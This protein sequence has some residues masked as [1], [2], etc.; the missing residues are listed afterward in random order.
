MNFK[1]RVDKLANYVQ[2]CER[3]RLPL[4][5]NT[6]EL[7]PEEKTWLRQAQFELAKK[8]ATMAIWLGK[9]YLNQRDQPE[10][11]IETEDADAYFTAAGLDQ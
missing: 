3:E 5:F 11:N 4:E 10:G 6:D 9:Q 8:N 2:Q 7:T 1:Q